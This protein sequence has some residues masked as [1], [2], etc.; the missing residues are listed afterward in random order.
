MILSFRVFKTLSI[1]NRM[2]WGAELLRACSPP[3][4]CHMSRVTCQLSHVRFQLSCVTYHMWQEWNGILKEDLRNYEQALNTLGLETLKTRREKLCLNFAPHFL[5][6]QK[7]AKLCPPSKKEHIMK[8]QESEHFEVFHA[9]TN[10]LQQSPIL[11]MQNLLN[12]E[13]KRKMQEE[14]QWN[15]WLV[16]M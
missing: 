6:N 5:K 14:L 1:A 12:N 2:S 7:M 15:I 11:Y 3:T 10:R 4:I 16:D 13:F 8:T 9:N